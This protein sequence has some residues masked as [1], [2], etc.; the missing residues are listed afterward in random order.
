MESVGTRVRIRVARNTVDYWRR[1]EFPELT[2]AID[3]IA[4][5][6][7][8]VCKLTNYSPK[9]GIVIG[10]ILNEAVKAKE[11][12]LQVADIN[13]NVKEIESQLN[14]RSRHSQH[15]SARISVVFNLE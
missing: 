8:G 1:A 6:S 12:S 15:L 9:L 7:G 13:Y 5:L 14:G 2:R 4:R 10:K 11:N 3:A